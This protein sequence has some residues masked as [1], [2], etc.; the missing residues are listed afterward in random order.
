MKISVRSDSVVIEGYVNAVERN[1]KPLIERGVKFVERIVAGCF[2]RAIRRAK[3]IRILQN[4][5]DNIDLGGISDG[6][7]TLEEDNIGLKA[8]AVLTAPEAIENAKRGNYIGWSFG[9]NDIDGGVDQLRDEETGLPLRRVKD[10]ELFEVSLL[11]R[12]RTPA[13]NG[14]LVNVRDDG[15]EERIRVNYSEDYEDQVEI[16]EEVEEIQEEIPEDKPEEI[17]EDVTSEAV[18]DPEP[19]KAPEEKKVSSDYFAKYKAMIDEW[20]K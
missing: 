20:R 15:S 18:S 11:T 2:N 12:D 14:T 1:S 16:K 4:H 5:D 6:N 13:Y 19:E 8:R 7:L 10:L 9:F 17:R 3:D